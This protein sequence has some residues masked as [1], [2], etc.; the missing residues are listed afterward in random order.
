MKI[1]RMCTHELFDPYNMPIRENDIVLIDNAAFVY[2]G[3][4]N[5]YRELIFRR[6]HGK[7]MAQDQMSGKSIMSYSVR[8]TTADLRCGITIKDKNGNSLRFPDA[9]ELLQISHD[10]MLYNEISVPPSAVGDRYI[11][12]GNPHYNLEDDNSPELTGDFAV[13]VEF[14][15]NSF[16]NPHSLNDTTVISNFDVISMGRVLGKFS[17]ELAKNKSGIPVGLKV[18]WKK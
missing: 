15:G 7:E 8:I 14:R 16:K 12:V 17:M 1:T 18:F 2:L 4:S 10:G 11:L 3:L 5:D 13:E 6:Y 9:C